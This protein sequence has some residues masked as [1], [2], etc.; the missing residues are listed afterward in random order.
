[1]AGLGKIISL[2]HF[3]EEIGPLHCPAFYLKSL[4][5][6]A[7]SHCPLP[8]CVSYRATTQKRQIILLLDLQGGDSIEVT[9]S[10]L[11]QDV[12]PAFQILAQ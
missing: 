11:V 9:V 6:S 3:T 10:E 12:P 8:A 2:L 5:N 7:F 4:F 1:M